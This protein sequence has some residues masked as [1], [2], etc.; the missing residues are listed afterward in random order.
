MPFGLPSFYFP[1]PF[2]PGVAKEL[3]AAR[4]GSPTN[5]PWPAYGH[6]GLQ[7]KPTPAGGF[8]LRS[9]VVGNLRFPPQTPP[10]LTAPAK[11]FRELPKSCPPPG[12]FSKKGG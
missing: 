10:S 2:F 8:P 5:A 6:S 11:V 4:R 7:S 12:I 9:N 3:L 1:Q